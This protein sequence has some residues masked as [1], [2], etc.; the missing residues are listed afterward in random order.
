MGNPNGAGASPFITYQACYNDAV[1]QGA[2][3]WTELS[4]R[5]QNYT[6]SIK[7][8]VSL[9]L[10][11]VLNIYIQNV[12]LHAA[13]VGSGQQELPQMVRKFSEFFH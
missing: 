12:M 4:G 7:D 13:A 11:L 10:G 6:F 3:E 1:A 8:S 5:F 9:F 2:T